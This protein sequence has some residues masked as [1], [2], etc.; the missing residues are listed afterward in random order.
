[1]GYN[2]QIYSQISNGQDEELSQSECIVSLATYVR[3][4]KL[5]IQNG[6]QGA[7]PTASW[8]P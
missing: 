1:M 5:Y 2:Y 4:K 6:R 3:C 7:G 8:R